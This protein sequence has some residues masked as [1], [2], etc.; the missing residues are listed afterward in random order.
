MD[1]LGT[2]QISLTGLRVYG[3]HGLFAHEQRDGQEFIVDVTVGFDLTAAG[4]SDQLQDTL[5]YG[6]LANR[7]ADIVGGPARQLIESVAAAVADDVLTDPRV[8]TVAVT[9]H[10]P[11]APIPLSF[12]DVAV[13]VHRA[14]AA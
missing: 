9:L 11:A 12:A 7:I 8:R 5:D 14:R 10:K 3:H 4:S 13:T 1:E 6:A 2:D